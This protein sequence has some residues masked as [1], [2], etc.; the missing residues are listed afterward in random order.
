MN[1]QADVC[2]VG[3]GPAGAFLGYLL[4]KKGISTV[5]IER[6]SG[7]NREF[8]GEHINAETEFLL[9]EHKLFEKIEEQGILKMSKVEFF[10]GKQL[11]K[12]ITPSLNEDHVGIH[13]P[14]SHLLKTVV[15][16]SKHYKNYRLLLNT[17]VTELVQDEKGFYTGV[18]ANQDGKEFIIKCS[19]IVGADGR[20]STVRKLANLPVKIMNH[21]YDVLWTKIPAPFGWEPTTRML[22]VNGHQLALFTQT[23]GFIQI[24]WNI[25]D[26]SFAALKKEP[27]LSFLEPLIET[28]PELKEIALKHLHSWN[29]FVCLNVHSS[30]CET[31]VKDGLVIIGDAAHTMTPTGAIG[32]NCAMKDAHVLAPTLIKALDEKNS[33]AERLSIF[34]ESRRAEI[35]KQ[36]EM[37]IEEEKT[38]SENFV[39]HAL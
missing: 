17:T 8:R 5:L 14:Q 22:L 37:Q 26:G 15:Q 7:K 36:Q 1:V 16:E 32:I 11:V 2:I 29:N 13:V 18:R 23:G 24:G 9:K 31:W 35:E 34:E 12:T 19:I 39:Q 25:K 10:A 4:A 30:H 20:F 21:G 3:C 38:F 27:F 33:S 6:S 28:L